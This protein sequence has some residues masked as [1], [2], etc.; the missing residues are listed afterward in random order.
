MGFTAS[1]QTRK[2]NVTKL[3]HF[4]F[5]I[6]N[7]MAFNNVDDPISLTIPEPYNNIA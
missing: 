1:C 4:L 7:K 5:T 3:G 2:Y 6:C